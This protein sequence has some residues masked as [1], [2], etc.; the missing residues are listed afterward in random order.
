MRVTG[1]NIVAAAP[2]LDEALLGWTIIGFA[3]TFLIGGFND[4]PTARDN[5]A[6]AFSVYQLSDAALLHAVAFSAAD[7]TEGARSGPC[8]ARLPGRVSVAFKDSGEHGGPRG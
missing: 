8:A 7:A 2:A 3:S 1:F 5:A 4:R 6:Y